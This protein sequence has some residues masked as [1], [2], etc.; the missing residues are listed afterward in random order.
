MSA[1]DAVKA[2]ED[3]KRKPKLDVTVE[4][5][6]SDVEKKPKRSKP[7]ETDIERIEWRPSVDEI[8]ALEVPDGND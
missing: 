7:V 4:V 6:A 1:K 2:R 8:E 3:A 5:S